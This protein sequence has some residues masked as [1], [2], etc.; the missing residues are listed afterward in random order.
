[1]KAIHLR[2]VCLAF[3]LL[4]SILVAVGGGVLAH[5]AGDGVARAVITAAAAF[6]AT[7]AL[8]L[9]TLSFLLRR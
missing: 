9:T 5:L 6:A 3:A 7:M 2:A 1:M 4:I 8:A